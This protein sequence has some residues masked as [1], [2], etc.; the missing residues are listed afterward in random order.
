MMDRQWPRQRDE[1]GEMGSRLTAAPRAR[2]EASPR[3]SAMPPEAIYGIFSSF[4]A[5]ASYR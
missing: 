3:P 2:A 4:A 1:E 5:R